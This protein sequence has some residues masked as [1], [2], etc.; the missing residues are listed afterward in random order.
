[1]KKQIF[2]LFLLIFSLSI[3]AKAIDFFIKPDTLYFPYREGIQM[4][5]IDYSNG[6]KIMNISDEQKKDYIKEMTSISSIFCFVNSSICSARRSSSYRGAT[7]VPVYPKLSLPIFPKLYV[8]RNKEGE[9]LSTYNNVRNINIRKSDFKPPEEAVAMDEI[10]ASRYG[11]LFVFYGSDSTFT[12]NYIHINPIDN[13]SKKGLFNRRGEVVLEAE[14]DQIYFYHL[15]NPII[16]KDG[17]FGFLGPDGKK[18]TPVIFQ[19]KD[20]SLRISNQNENHIIT[21]IDSLFG[22]VDFSGKILLEFNFM[23]LT[24]YKDYYVFSKEGEVGIINFTTMEYIVPLGKYDYIE[25]SYY[26]MLPR[27][28]KKNDLYG[29]IDE[30]YKEVIS[31]QFDT[32]I[33]IG[34]ASN[35]GYIVK[36][37]G[38]YGFYDANYELRIPVDFEDIGLNKYGMTRF[39]VQDRRHFM[40]DKSGGKWES[41]YIVKKDSL[42]GVYDESFKQVIPVQYDAILKHGTFFKV[43]KEDNWGLYNSNLQLLCEPVLKKEFK[44][45][46]FSWGYSYDII[47]THDGKKGIIG[48]NDCFV[49]PIYDDIRYIKNRYNR[50]YFRVWEEKKVK[51]LKIKLGKVKGMGRE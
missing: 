45:V 18:I 33:Q 46:V 22:I 42:Y 26:T 20:N 43:K 13:F 15:T 4:I 3:N 36:K 27:K 12:D 19:L 2:Y 10:T 7:S 47:I 5:V 30:E 24:D 35:A 11:E 21:S 49:P 34:A 37:D 1:M 29:Y 23:N 44:S 38:L 25:Q 48:M 17:K 16:V 41:C 14:Y 6:E 51:R 40:L 9:I 32:I 28:V 39:V 50:I 31:L 8:F